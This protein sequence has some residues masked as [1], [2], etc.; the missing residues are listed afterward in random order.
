MSGSNSYA[1]YLHYLSTPNSILRNG[2]IFTP[3]PDGIDA[4]SDVTMTDIPHASPGTDSFHTPN[5]RSDLCTQVV[6]S[7][8]PNLTFG[9]DKQV[10]RFILFR[11][12][13]LIHSRAQVTM[14]LKYLKEM[15]RLFPQEGREAICSALN[16]AIKQSNAAKHR[17]EIYEFQLQQ[18]LTAAEETSNHA[19]R[20]ASDYTKSAD[21]V[22]AIRSAFREDLGDDVLTPARSRKGKAR[23][24]I[25]EEDDIE[26]PP[27]VSSDERVSDGSE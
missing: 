26:L 12:F 14:Q 22:A 19:I 7:A 9:H 5:T 6:T 17:I 13:E 16:T 20:A 15:L 11:H 8:K 18:L 23:S 1:R 24:P 10:S 3:N 2:L 27:Y 25:F 21:L 4:A